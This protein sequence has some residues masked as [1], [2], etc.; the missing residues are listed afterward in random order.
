M[1]TFDPSLLRLE[2]IAAKG[3]VSRLVLDKW[4]EQNLFPRPTYFTEDGQDWYPPAYAEL[5][6]RA[7]GRKMTLKK[8]FQSDF[9]RVLER[10]RRTDPA[11]YQAELT[12]PG[13]LEIS[14]ENLTESNWQG[15]L[16]GEY[17]ACLRVAW[18][19]C[20]LRKSKLMRS[21]EELA[22]KPELDDLIWRS[23]LR[24]SVD[25]LDRLEMPFAQWDR[26]RFGKPVSRDT[27]IRAIRLR[28]PEVFGL[29]P[30]RPEAFSPMPASS[31]RE[32]LTC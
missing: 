1:L 23:K 5:V 2:S 26:I 29:K 13:G 10:L 31:P 15:F 4:R 22:A 3:G 25:S 8:L 32:E 27:H 12:G 17:G 16:S 14:P 19:P 28:F 6:R 9:K 18:V 11:G 24:R 7:I 30:G 20:M 21:I